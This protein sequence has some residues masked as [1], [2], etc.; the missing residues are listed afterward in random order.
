MCESEEASQSELG[1]SVEAIIRGVQSATSRLFFEPG[2]ETSS[3]LDQGADTNSTKIDDSTINKE[4]GFAEEDD[5]DHHHAVVNENP[6]ESSVALA[7]ESEDPY[8]DFRRS[9]EEMVEIHGLMSDWRCLEELL[10]WYLRV[11]GEKNHAYIVGAFVDLL[12]GIASN[13]ISSSTTTTT[14]S[15]SSAAHSFSSSS[16]TSSLGQNHQICEEEGEKI[17]S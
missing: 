7:M 5:D 4:K 15:F 11:N 16:P 12:A 1:E 6:F 17:M 8:G 13:K 14:D 10:S 9:M 2:G 3:I